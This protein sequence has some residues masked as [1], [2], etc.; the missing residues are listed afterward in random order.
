MSETKR[1]RQTFLEGT[2]VLLVAT[3][4][5]KVISAV[6]RIPLTNLLSSR[7]MGYYA[8]AYDLYV[9]IYTIALAGLPVAISRL[10]AEKAAVGRYK[11]VKKILNVS[12]KVFLVTGSVGFIIMFGL[13][14]YSRAITVLRYLEKR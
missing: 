8:T 3:A 10:V 7:G 13:A 4:I 12:F 11:D 6:Y 14:F 5:A 2:F 9:P 1:K